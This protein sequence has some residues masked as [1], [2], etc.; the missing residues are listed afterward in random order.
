VL[1]GPSPPTRR[2]RGDRP[3]ARRCP[4]GVAGRR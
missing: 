3:P 2:R 1:A 4:G